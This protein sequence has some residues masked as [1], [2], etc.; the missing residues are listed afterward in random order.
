MV[1]DGDI[2]IEP[3]HRP[4]H[5]HRAVIQLRAADPLW[6]GAESQTESA[7]GSTVVDAW[8]LANGSIAPEHVLDHG[9]TPAIGEAWAYT[10]N[11]SWE[12]TYSIAIKTDSVDPHPGL[13]YLYNVVNATDS[14][15]T[16]IIWDGDGS[17]WYVNDQV[18]F[19]FNIGGTAHYIH[20]YNQGEHNIY[21][22]TVLDANF[23][24]IQPIDGTAR[25]WRSGAPGNTANS[26]DSTLHLY[27]IYDIALDSD[28]RA[29]LNSALSG[30]VSDYRQLNVTAVNEGDINVYPV[31]T[32]TGPISEPSIRNTATN[33]TLNF[34]THTIAAGNVYSIDLRPGAKTIE[35]QD[36]VNR[37]NE[38]TSDAINAL[39]SW[40][41]APA[42]VV[43]GGTN[44]IE[45]SG[46]ATSNNTNFQITFTNRYLSY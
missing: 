10:S 35:D 29:A 42:P 11:L 24:N 8:W 18:A 21:R 5:L 38:L 23:F 3:A 14:S 6:R 39:A 44:I 46:T 16:N 27:A 20:T 37:I 30:S 1:G 22:G 43:T 26:W 34:G 36:G 33:E 13:N 19:L 9:G 41:L 7:P 32:V 28:Q 25:S 45:L 15:D 12:D 31:I 2:P 4:G 40:H 17:D